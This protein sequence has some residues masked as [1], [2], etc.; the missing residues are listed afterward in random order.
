MTLLTMMQELTDVTSN[1]PQGCKVRLAKEEDLN[2]WDVT[3]DG[4]DDSIY[5]VS[6]IQEV[7]LGLRTYH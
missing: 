4:P 2:I 3:M 5:K 6:A 1:P 7:C